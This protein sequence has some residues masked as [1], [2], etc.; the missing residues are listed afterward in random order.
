MER[1]QAHQV[2]SHPPKLDSFGFHQPLDG[3]GPLQPVDDFLG[4]VGHPNQPSS[5]NPVKHY[6][7]LQLS[8]KIQFDTVQGQ[9]VSDIGFTLPLPCQG[10]AL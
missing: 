3:D 5:K 1:A 4:N 7:A 10:K 6:L 2:L 9:A 8:I